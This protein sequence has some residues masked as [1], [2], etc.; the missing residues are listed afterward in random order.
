MTRF[1]P[2][3]V[4]SHT[5]KNRIVVPP[6]ASQTADTNGLA[7]ENTINHY[8]NLSRSGAG[9]VM[10]EYSFVH[11]TGRS[12]TNQLGAHSDNCIP[13]MT[14]IANV[15][16]NAG[17][18]AGFQLTH[19]G[20]KAQLDV[21]PDL[22]APSGITVPAYDRTLP[23]PK[24]MSLQDMELWAESFVKAA[25]RVDKAGFDFVELHCA[26][27]YGLNQVL[28]PITN[29]RGDHYGGSLVNRTRLIV[30]IVTEIKSKT[31]LGIM[32]RIPGQDLY[33]EGLTQQDMLKVCQLLIEAGVDIID[34]SS[35]IGGWNRPKDRRGEGYL[36]SESEYL[37]KADLSV[38][39]IGVGGI[40]SIEYIE[41]SLEQQRFDLAAIGRAI[42][43]DPSNFA[44]N[45]MCSEAPAYS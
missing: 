16:H 15:I 29:Q 42:L 27:G 19:C 31:A 25:V 14:A 43:K 7:T 23:E 3:H 4:N 13:G 37:K 38:P 6:M 9:L 45:I 39:I 41:Q 34:V 30:E 24:A 12:E 22:M 35:G 1:T 20:G 18:K 17:S 8:Q 2:L 33:P 32:V 36:V 5:L 11:P 44:E 26:H 28:S 40:E 21:C 10:V